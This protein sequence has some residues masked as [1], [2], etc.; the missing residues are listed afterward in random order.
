MHQVRSARLSNGYSVV[1]LLH[2]SY[3]S[4]ASQLFHV[5]QHYWV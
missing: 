4:D 5:I 2:R 3:T 1:I